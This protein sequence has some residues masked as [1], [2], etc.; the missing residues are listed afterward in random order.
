[1][2]FGIFC[3]LN[4]FFQCGPSL[5]TYVLPA[6][7]FPSEV[8]STC[9]GISAT[10]GKLGAM[11]GALAFPVIRRGP[12]GIVGVLWLEAGACIIGAVLSY[13][14]LRNDWEYLNEDDKTATM[15]FVHGSAA[16]FL[17]MSRRS[18]AMRPSLAGT[19][20]GP[21]MSEAKKQSS[22]ASQV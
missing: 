13:Q 20:Q 10:G 17:G 14:F 19:A 22:V 7:C 16:S 2:I 6:I 11:A 8:R 9:H 1:V 12:L 3:I 15:T 4:F 21:R 18:S 5:G